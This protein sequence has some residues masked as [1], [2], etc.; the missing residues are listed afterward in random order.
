[1]IQIRRR[2]GKNSNLVLAL[3]S[4]GLVS[5]SCSSGSGSDPTDAID[6]VR[7]TA[8]ADY[9][10]DVDHVTPDDSA[11]ATPL[12]DTYKFEDLSVGGG[13]WVTGMVIHPSEANL[14]YARTDVGGAY[15]WD[16]SQQE[17]IQL[18]SS[19]TVP[20]PVSSDWQVASVSTAPSDSD[21]VYLAVGK[22]AE[23]PTGRILASQDQGNTWQDHGRGFVIAGNAEDRVGAERLATDPDDSDIVWFGSRTEGLLVSVDGSRTW[24]NVASVPSGGG[25]DVNST[26]VKW[27]LSTE[28]G[29][30]VGVAHSGVYRVSGDPSQPDELVAEQL[31]STNAVPLDAELGADGVLWVAELGPGRVQRFDVTTNLVTDVSPK[32]DQEYVSVAIDP[33]DPETVFIGRSTISSNGLW[34]TTTSGEGWSEIGATSSCPDIP[35]LEEYN[36]RALSAGSMTFDPSGELWFPEGFGMWRSTDLDDDEI[37]FVCETEGIEELVSNDLIVTPAG[38]VLSAHWDRAIFRHGDGTPSGAEQGPNTEFNSAWDLDWS[39]ADPD[40]VVGVVSD[41]RFCC[42][43]GGDAYYSSYS[44]DGG[45]NWQRFE[46]YENGTHPA[47]LRFG[48]IAV[49]ASDTDNLVWMPTFNAPLHFSH[50]QG[51][52][53]TEVVLPGTEDNVTDGKNTGG[54]HFAYYLNRNVLQADRILPDTFYLYHGELG[55]FRSSD[56]GE[57]WELMESSGL[58]L[59]WPVGFFNAKLVSVPDQP[60]HLVFTPG[61]LEEGS[62]P[63]Y[64]SVDGGNIWSEILGTGNVTAIGFGVAENEGGNATVYLAGEVNGVSG[65]WRSTDRRRTW[66]LISSAPAGNYQPIRAISGDPSVF[67]TVYVAMEGTTAKVGEQSKP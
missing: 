37:T 39:P 50:D 31:W 44:T 6:V 58:P 64:E 52:T 62:W 47:D 22:S 23:H 25:D 13:G 3:V 19:E 29:V 41:H 61:V 26:G 60:G 2:A 38:S 16:E 30:F 24:S 63:A 48:N 53:W 28:V 10:T 43:S 33:T 15:R 36:H 18:I 20:N 34:R 5:S 11:V 40:F 67:G 45:Q 66:S 32:G 49:S 42:E 8:P 14:R 21:V 51:A 54:S 1:M 12:S 46:S 7:P 27:V 4:L 65:V 9:E 17:W 35:W 55:I 59:G 57:T 56:A